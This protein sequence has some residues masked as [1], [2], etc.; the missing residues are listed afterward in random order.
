M[1]I[2][3]IY[4][5]ISCV[6]LAAA[7]LSPILTAW[8]NNRYQFKMKA[9]EVEHADQQSSTLHHRQIIENYLMAAGAASYDFNLK[10]AA[11][12]SKYYALAFAYLPNDCYEQMRKLNSIIEDRNIPKSRAEFE[13]LAL[14]VKSYIPK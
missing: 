6:T 8:I 13:K 5:I 3:K 9:L 11:E 4:I 12:Y 1:N 14:I 7:I 10:N 2:D